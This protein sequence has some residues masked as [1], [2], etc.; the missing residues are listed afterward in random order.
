M[1]VP[2]ETLWDIEPHTKAKHEILRRYLQAWFPILNS[3]NDRIVYVDGFC[4]P[5]RYKGGEPGSPLITLEVAINHR[6]AMRGKLVFWFIDEREDRILHLKQELK[7]LSIPPHFKVRPELGKFHERLGLVLDAMETS[8]TNLAPTFAFI[9]PF[10]FSGIP[11]TLIQRLLKQE[12]CEAFITFM[13]DSINRFLEHPRDSIVRHIVDAFGTD[14]AIRIAESSGNRIEKL[15]VLY[16]NQL[17]RVAKFVRYFEMRD[18]EDRTQYYLFFATNNELGHLKM[19]EAMWRVD[20]GGEFRFSDETNPNQRVL[21]EF[22]PTTIL[23]KELGDRFRGKGLI[24]VSTVHK[25]VENETAYLEKHMRNALREEAR[26]GRVTVD[27]IK[28]G[29]QKRR[30]NTFPDDARITFT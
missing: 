20:P 5:G 3:W 4:G 8:G 16:Q 14:E 18:Q 1:A 10:G 25:Y 7:G 28:V 29:G 27:P 26:T 6:Q 12:R 24:P 23:A 30:V 15:R 2:L 9:D 11:Y 22:D 17:R 13:V 21:F 19:K